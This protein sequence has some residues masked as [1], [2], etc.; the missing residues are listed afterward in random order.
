MTPLGK[1]RELDESTRI[2]AGSQLERQPGGAYSA[3]EA[4][5]D[6]ELLPKTSPFNSENL[7]FQS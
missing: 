3:T 2:V 6:T 1:L 4:E 5:V 7:S